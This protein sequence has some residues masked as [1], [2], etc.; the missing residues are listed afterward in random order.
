MKIIRITNIIYN[1]ATCIEII[2]SLS[3]VLDDLPEM[4]ND[5]IR[6]NNPSFHSKYGIDYTNFFIYYMFNK[7]GISLR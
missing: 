6:R 7:I 3:L 2:H 5:S 4:D 1:I